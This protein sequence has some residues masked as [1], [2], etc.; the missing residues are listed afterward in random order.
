MKYILSGLLLLVGLNLF[1]QKDIYQINVKSLSVHAKADPD[2]RIVGELKKGDAFVLISV[3]DNWHEIEFGKKTGFILGPSL[4]QGEFWT[5]RAGSAGETT[6]A[7]CEDFESIYDSKLNNYLQINA[8]NDRDIVIKLMQ[9]NPGGDKCI[10][11]AYVEAGNEMKIRNIPEGTYYVKVAYGNNW[12]VTR[13]NNI[14]YGKF[15]DS[16]IYEKGADLFDF[17]VTKTD[18]GYQ[19]PSYQLTLEIITNNPDG[20]VVENQIS[21][22]EFNN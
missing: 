13:H 18:N 20:K 7:I 4:N 9:Q 5:K 2:S 6:K 22:E 10:R 12:K 17:S 19:V 1:A 3:Q 16:A 8:G 15:S 11:S 14:C 21:E